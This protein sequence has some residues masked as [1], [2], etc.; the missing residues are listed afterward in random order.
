MK[1]YFASLIAAIMMTAGLVAFTEGT[2]TAAC[3]YTGCITTYTS[4]DAPAQ[5][6]RHNRARIGVRVFTD[7]NGEPKGSVTIRVKR[8]T[9]GYS[10]INSKRYTGDKVWFTTTRLHKL[11][12]YVVTARFDRKAGSA[13]KDSNNVAT[14]RVVRR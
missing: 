7:G 10:Y 1:K 4:V 11:G 5:V 8:T 2:A 9:G 12:K 3:P 6:K 14:F 13:F